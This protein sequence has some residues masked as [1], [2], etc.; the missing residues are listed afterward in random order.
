MTVINQ[1]INL[2]SNIPIK[3][4]VNSREELVNY[5]HQTWEL[6]EWLF[7]AIKDEASYYQNPDPLRHPLIFY[8]GHTAVF[9]INKLVMAGLLAKGINPHYET[10]FAK[11]V[12]PDLPQNLETH[13]IW[14][15]VAEV[16]AY[17][18]Q[19]F[20][21]V[22]KLIREVDIP[23]QIDQNHPLWALHMG[24][25]HDRI[26]FETSSVLIRQM[27][28]SLLQ[29]P[30]GW[31]YAPSFGQPENNEL[32][33]C[34]GGAVKL[35]KPLA[36]AIFGW[37]NEY[38][39]LT[40]SVKPF[41]AYKNLVSNA[42]YLEF[43]ESNAYN[44]RQ[45]W[46]EEGWEWKER[47][48]AKHP[49]FWVLHNGTFR[50]RAMFDVMDMP[51]DWPVEVNALEAWAYCKWKGDEWRLLSEAEFNL[52]G[53]ATLAQEEDPA[54]STAHNLHVKYG[55]PT[56]VGYLKDSQTA[57]G[58]NDIFGNVWDWLAD[59]FYPLP[60]FE[61]HPYYEDFSMPY[62]DEDHSMILGGAWATTGTGASKYYRLW[63]R[64]S[65]FQHAGFRMAKDL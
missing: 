20:Q 7:S 28:S 64:R 9:Y 56:P 41:A 40:V 58:F 27:D 36:D 17:R 33:S 2:L 43:V 37:D 42:E 51:L 15:T 8:W 3:L 44:D 35:G 47:V 1:E 5:F 16:N 60:G 54:L 22:E 26:H 53:S 6:Y 24:F 13:D 23:E 45:Y 19:V 61:I 18:Q 14:P 50:Y 29:Q 48:Q 38:G 34:Q 12:D 46:T 21:T 62:F 32:I 63:F 57:R 49:K 10:L 39:A 52:I 59:D 55:S 4:K 65:F 30:E 11:G 25:E 31:E